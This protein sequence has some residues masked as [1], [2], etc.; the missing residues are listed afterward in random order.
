[1]TRIFSFTQ[2]LDVDIVDVFCLLQKGFTE[3]RKSVV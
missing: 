1:M 2:P 3:D